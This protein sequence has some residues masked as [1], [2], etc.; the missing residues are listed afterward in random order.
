MWSNACNGWAWT[1]TGREGLE[2]TAEGG[3]CGEEC[4]RIGVF[5][6]E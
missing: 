6:S 2:A 4:G 3:E 5:E 1:S